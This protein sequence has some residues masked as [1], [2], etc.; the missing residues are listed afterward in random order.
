[1]KTVLMAA[2]LAA[3]AA[4]SAQSQLDTSRNG[5]VNTGAS[6]SVMGSQPVQA[7]PLGSQRVPTTVIPPGSTAQATAI[8]PLNN[9]PGTVIP[10]VPN[11]TSGAVGTPGI[12]SP[13][14]T[15]GVY[16]AGATST[17]SGSSADSNPSTMSDEDY[18]K[19]LNR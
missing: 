3:S 10:A 4:A 2:L 8:P 6:V 5:Q 7:L 14:G 1:M 19:S 11:S 15:S 17:A 16:G 13:L 18:R 12:T 9:V